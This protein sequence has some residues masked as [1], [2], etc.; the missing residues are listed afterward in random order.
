MKKNILSFVLALI[1]LVSCFSFS[2]YAFSVPKNLKSEYRL[3]DSIGVF[4]NTDISDNTIFVTRAQFAA[5]VCNLFNIDG[6]SFPDGGYFADVRSDN[7]AYTAINSL[8]ALGYI[9]GTDVNMFS[10]TENIKIEHAVKIII[11]V[12]GNKP[13]AEGVGTGIKGYIDVAKTLGIWKADYKYDELIM[14][15]D[16]V[17]MLYDVLF[18]YPIE[19]TGI[20]ADSIKYETDKDETV[21]SK[22]YDIYEETAVVESVNPKGIDSDGESAAYIGGVLYKAG[23]TDVYDFLGYEADFFYHLNEKSGV[24][25]LVCVSPSENSEVLKISSEDIGGF[26]G[27]AYTYSEDGRDKTAKIASDADFYLNGAKINYSKNLAVPEYGSVTLIKYSSKSAAGYNAVVIEDNKYAVV[28]SL[29]TDDNSVAF[30]DSITYTVKNGFSFDTVTKNAI[31]PSGN[32]DFYYIVSDSANNAKSFTDLAKGMIVTLNMNPDGEG[33]RV[34]FSDKK[35]TGKVSE[36]S[37]DFETVKIGTENYDVRYPLISK[38]KIFLGLDAEFY[39]DSDGKIVYLK[40]SSNGYRKG[41]AV[42][43]FIPEDKK[44]GVRAVIFDMD[45]KVP[46]EVD[47]AD[48]VKVDGVVKTVETAAD[49]K[50]LQEKCRR[51]F[52]VSATSPT[53]YRTFEFLQFKLNSKGELNEINL[54]GSPN[55]P[56]FTRKNTIEEN[57]SELLVRHALNTIGDKAIF[58]DSTLYA[59]IPYTTGATESYLDNAEYFIDVRTKYL[60]S[61]DYKI[62][63]YCDLYYFDD[64]MVIDAIVKFGFNLK[65]DSLNDTL[66]KYRMI[67]ASFNDIAMVKKITKTVLDGDTADKISFITATGEEKEYIVSPKYASDVNG[68]FSLCE[69]GLDVGDVFAYLTKN[70]LVGNFVKVYDAS[71]KDVKSA[72]LG[73]PLSYLDTWSAKPSKNVKVDEATSTSGSYSA[74]YR[75]TAGSVYE[76][77]GNVMAVSLGNTTDDSNLAYFDITNVP[78]LVYDCTGGKETVKLGSDADVKSAVVY[79]DNASKTAVHIRSGKMRAVMIFNY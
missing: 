35:I 49:A 4:E 46:S 23:S 41:F 11:S 6:V 36:I 21:L 60:L 59:S 52:Y 5:S 8:R 32:S 2:A 30:D 63:N 40:N 37:S 58:N 48:K 64:D 45:A 68:D 43:F 29:N 75:L 44:D 15:E 9:S 71:V 55:V 78:I 70:D 66:S 16:F 31:S 27:S 42:R 12:L 53:P 20:T 79:G 14:K 38:D 61:N 67:P 28:K 56:D 7:V 39:L 57:M 33:A 25:T 65:T 72:F 74:T 24:K 76:I 34:R 47:V 51:T 73:A 10:P 69:Q 3:L 17:S 62:G 18:S 1:I 13:V 19:I 54:V 26:S 50:E 77:K 22:Y